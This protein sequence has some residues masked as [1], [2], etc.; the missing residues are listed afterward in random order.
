MLSDAK[1]KYENAFK[2][3]SASLLYSA[4]WWLDATCGSRGWDVCS[5][6]DPA[7]N[8]IALI[9]YYKSVIHGMQAVTTPPMTQW[10]PVLP[11]TGKTSISLEDFLKQLP[12]YSILD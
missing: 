7:G 5:V 4:P 2:M 3:Q 6:T 8:G 10:L 9:P 11:L 1:V 12:A